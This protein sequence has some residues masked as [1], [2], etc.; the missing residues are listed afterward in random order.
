MFYCCLNQLFVVLSVHFGLGP[1]KR[2]GMVELHQWVHLFVWH[3]LHPDVDLQ[4]SCTQAGAFTH[5]CAPLQYQQTDAQVVEKTHSRACTSIHTCQKCVGA[6][7]TYFSLSNKHT[8]AHSQ[9]KDTAAYRDT[10][11]H[12]LH[13]EKITTLMIYRS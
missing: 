12:I 8:H 9:R 5:L 3:L 1:I 2:I 7:L 10:L 6:I 4:L 11:S 13:L